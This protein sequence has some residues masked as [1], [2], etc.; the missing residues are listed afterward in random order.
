MES[1]FEFKMELLWDGR[2]VDIYLET[3]EYFR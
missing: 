1:A 2:L 3:F